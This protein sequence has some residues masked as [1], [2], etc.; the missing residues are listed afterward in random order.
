VGRKEEWKEGVNGIQ[1]VHEKKYF[2]KR[3]KTRADV[4]PASMEKRII[5][6]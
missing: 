5:E 2:G 6:R 1:S 3:E 4:P